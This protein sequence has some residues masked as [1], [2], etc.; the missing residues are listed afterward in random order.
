MDRA[1]AQLGVPAG[2][3]N[4]EDGVVHV[5]TDPGRSVHYGELIGDGLKLEV[6]AK[7]T[8]KKAPEYKI[9]GKSIRAWTSRARSP[10]SSPMCTTSACR[11]CCTRA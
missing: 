7:I 5:K 10:A 6:D 11:E 8:L 4:V 1:A 9:I 2:E 3:L